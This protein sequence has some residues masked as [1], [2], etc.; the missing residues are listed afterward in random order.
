MP[1]IDLSA[2]ETDERPSHLRAVM[3]TL[4]GRFTETPNSRA[5]VKLPALGLQ[6]VARLIVINA[7]QKPTPSGQKPL[8]VLHK[9]TRRYRVLL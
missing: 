1:F 6:R 8:P 7:V 5:V 2:L 3:Q 9:K 4:D